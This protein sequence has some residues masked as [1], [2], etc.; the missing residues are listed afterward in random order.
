MKIRKKDAN[1]KIPWKREDLLLI[2]EKI[3]DSEDSEVFCRFLICYAENYLA[4]KTTKKQRFIDS[5]EFEAYCDSVMHYASECEAAKKK[6]KDK[7]EG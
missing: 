3:I 7:D 2:A 6:A 1:E 5:P 4:E